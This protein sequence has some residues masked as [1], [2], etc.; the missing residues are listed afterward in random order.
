VLRAMEQHPGVDW[1]SRRVRFEH[2]DAIA[3]D[4][5][6]RALAMGVIVVQNPT[7]F[8]LVDLI[9]AR[10]GAETPFFPL[11]TLLEAGIPVALGSDGPFNPYLN[12][13]LASIDPVHPTEAITREQAVEA[14]THGS[15]YAAFMENGTGRLEPGKLADLAVLSQDI[16]TV[17]PDRLPA[18]ES[19][20]TIIGGQIVYG[21]LPSTQ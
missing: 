17:S 9:A 16:F 8:S 4:L 6:P 5:I 12:I 1:K 10:Y 19:V 15:A 7:H 11:R 13:M 18:T 21:S 2:G 3:G 14:Y 20:L